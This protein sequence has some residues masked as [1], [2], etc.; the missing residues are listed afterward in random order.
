VRE[1]GRAVGEPI[2]PALVTVGRAEALSTAAA[3]L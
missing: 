2:T 1:P 3:A